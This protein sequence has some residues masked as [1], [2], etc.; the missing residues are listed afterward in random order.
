MLCYVFFTLYL[1]FRL[2]SIRNPYKTK[3][4]FLTFALNCAILDK[5]NLYVNIL[6]IGLGGMD[7]D[8]IKNAKGVLNHEIF[9]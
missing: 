9:H 6:A 8:K 7:R 4:L 3:V 2:F 5:V 1:I